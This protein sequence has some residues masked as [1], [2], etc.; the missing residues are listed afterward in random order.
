[1]Y[2]PFLNKIEKKF[3][4]KSVDNIKE[5]TKIKLIRKILE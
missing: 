2:E 5:M 4:K 3:G 1:M